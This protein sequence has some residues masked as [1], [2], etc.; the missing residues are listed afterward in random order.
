TPV[1]RKK[2]PLGGALIGG[3]LCRALLVPLLTLA[4]ALLGCGK[5]PTPGETDDEP[6]GSAAQALCTVQQAQACDEHNPC[7]IDNCSNGTCSHTNLANGASC[8][9]GKVCEGA[10][11]TCISGCFIGGTVFAAAA[12]NPSNACEVCTPTTSTT[13]WSNQP[14]GTTCN[15]GNACTQTD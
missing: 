13:A 2:S 9:T 3:A 6:V 12:T 15:D 10:G 11:G 7:R 8:G 5:A 4:L 1:Y 14:N